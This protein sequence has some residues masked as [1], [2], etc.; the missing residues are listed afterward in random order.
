MQAFA[1]NIVTAHSCLRQKWAQQSVLA[2]SLS[3]VGGL[4]YQVI[5]QIAQSELGSLKAIYSI[6]LSKQQ[7]EQ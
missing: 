7:K 1:L 6:Q 4:E 5:E 3:T 2:T